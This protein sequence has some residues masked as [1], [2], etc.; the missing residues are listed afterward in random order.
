MTRPFML[1]RTRSMAQKMISI[2][3]II[4]TPKS[5]RGWIKPLPQ[6]MI[7]WK[8]KTIP[9]IALERTAYG[10]AAMMKPGTIIR[11]GSREL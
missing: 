3:E 11:I 6:R 9:T 2:I 7:L 4:L 5:M 10:I 1:D 8:E